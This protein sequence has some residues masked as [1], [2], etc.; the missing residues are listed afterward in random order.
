MIAVLQIIQTLEDKMALKPR[1]STGHKT[2]VRT[3]KLDTKTGRLEPIK[4]KL[5]PHVKYAMEKRTKVKRGK[6]I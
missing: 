3:H 6:R 5:P 2:T 1:P 4:K